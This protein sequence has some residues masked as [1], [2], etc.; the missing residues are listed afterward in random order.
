M[1]PF[2]CEERSENE[3][4]RFIKRGRNWR[5]A[6]MEMSGRSGCQLLFFKNLI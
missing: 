3:M 4:E 1:E 2:L 6:A 5:G